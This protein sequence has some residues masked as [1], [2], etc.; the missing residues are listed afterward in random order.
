MKQAIVTLLAGAAAACSQS[1]SRTLRTAE[2]ADVISVRYLLANVCIPFIEHPESERELTRVAHLRRIHAFAF[3]QSLSPKLHQ[4]VGAY[5]DVTVVNIT[6]ESCLI[7]V[8]RG[9]YQALESSVKN[10]LW[11]SGV[12]W[13]EVASRGPVPAV[14]RVYCRPGGGAVTT[15]EDDPKRVATVQH[16]ATFDVEAMTDRSECRSVRG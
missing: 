1:P 7:H 6:N 10:V 5:D 12:L 8:D 4:Y 2:P 16:E 3:P 9:N 14:Q 11:T 13:P 15:F